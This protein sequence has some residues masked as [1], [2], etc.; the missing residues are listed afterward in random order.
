MIVPCVEMLGVTPGACVD[1][2]ALLA[3]VCTTL[4]TLFLCSGANNNTVADFGVGANVFF[5]TES[6]VGI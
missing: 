5:N 4:L 3:G 2:L 6:A 1:T